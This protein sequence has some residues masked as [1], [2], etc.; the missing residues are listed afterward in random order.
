MKYL[1][2]HKVNNTC[3]VYFRSFKKWPR[4]SSPVLIRQSP[5]CRKNTKITSRR[6]Q[7]KCKHDCHS[8]FESRG[9]CAYYFHVLIVFSINSKVKMCTSR[10]CAVQYFKSLSSDTTQLKCMTWHIPLSHF[11]TRIYACKDNFNKQ[12]QNQRE[13]AIERRY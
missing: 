4:Y 7:G 1:F 11:T 6:V 5:C 12:R 3:W 10:L 13:L 9:F 8:I 2:W